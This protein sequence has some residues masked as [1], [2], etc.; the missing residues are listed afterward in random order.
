[1]TLDFPPRDDAPPTADRRVRQQLREL[2]AQLTA[3]DTSLGEHLAAVKLLR[4][5]RET[6]IDTLRRTLRD[7]LSWLPLDGDGR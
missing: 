5:H 3:I 4:K 6:V 2:D 1:M 7:E